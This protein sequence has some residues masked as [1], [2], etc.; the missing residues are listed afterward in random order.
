MQTKKYILISSLVLILNGCVAPQIPQSSPS[1]AHSPFTHGN[2]QMT[3]KPN[4][5]TQ[6]QIIEVFG[7]PN[8]ATTDTSGN[9]V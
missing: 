9:E 4:I 2:V 8:I 5:T 7:P 3:I 6:N 1:A